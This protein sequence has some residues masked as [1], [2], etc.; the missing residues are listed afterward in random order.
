MKPIPEWTPSSIALHQS[1]DSMTVT[2][3]FTLRPGLQLQTLLPSA[4]LP[5]TYDPLRLPHPIS[6]S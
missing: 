4:F 1:C 3:L 2:E 6:Y 5:F